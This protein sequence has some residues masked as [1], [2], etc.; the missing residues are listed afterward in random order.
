MLLAKPLLTLALREESFF[1]LSGVCADGPI[2]SG[3]C[4]FALRWLAAVT[5]GHKKDAGSPPRGHF[6]K[7]TQTFSYSLLKEGGNIGFYISL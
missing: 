4:R 2:A 6:L 7:N 1:F 5:E 3:V